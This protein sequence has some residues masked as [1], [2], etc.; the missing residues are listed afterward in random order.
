MLSLSGEQIV[1]FMQPC[2]F[3]A[4]I[5]GC[6]RAGTAAGA[7]LV[8]LGGKQV[9]GCRTGSRMAELLERI[10]KVPQGGEY[11]NAVYGYL[12]WANSSPDISGYMYGARTRGK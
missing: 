11:L 5:S 12:S 9:L 8:Q 1:E 6:T 3:A 4:I 10:G 7:E 2:D